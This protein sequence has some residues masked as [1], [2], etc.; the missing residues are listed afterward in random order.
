MTTKNNGNK[1]S[2]REEKKKR[3]KKKSSGSEGTL[4]VRSCAR[5]Q[6]VGG[7]GSTVLFP[8]FGVGVRYRSLLRSV[9]GNVCERYASEQAK[10]KEKLLESWKKQRSVGISMTDEDEKHGGWR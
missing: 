3:V 9:N 5:A 10:E 7:V 4:I 8:R 6:S 1:R 2:S